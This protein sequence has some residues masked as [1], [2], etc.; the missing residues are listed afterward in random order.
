MPTRLPRKF[1]RSQRNGEA[2]NLAA[3]NVQT[4]NDRALQSDLLE[5]F[6]VQSPRTLAQLQQLATCDMSAAK[7]AAH[8]LKGSAR[9]IGAFKVADA[10]AEVERTL[11]SKQNAGALADL[12]ANLDKAL[13]EIKAYMRALIVVRRP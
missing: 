3:L 12:A 2:L 4:G 10:A 5:L 7:A 6:V 8:K 9:A 13:S 11:G 1:R